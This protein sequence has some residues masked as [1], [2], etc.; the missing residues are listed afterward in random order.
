[1]TWP[2]CWLSSA[3]NF[4][5]ASGLVGK[6]SPPPVS[7][8][9]FAAGDFRPLASSSF[10]RCTTGAG[11]PAGT[12]AANQQPMSQPSTLA[13]AIVGT[14]GRIA[15]RLLVDMPGARSLPALNCGTPVEV[16]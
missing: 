5:S 10:S 11:V 13:L 12:W 4:A 9:A 16:R 6:G 14:S 15:S 1:M 8:Q 7:K 2:H 3:W